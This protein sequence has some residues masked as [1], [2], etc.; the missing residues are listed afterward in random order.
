MPSVNIKIYKGHDKARR[1]SI[2]RRVTEAIS[3]ETK[4]PQQYIWVIIEES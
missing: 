4:V 1:D 2:A 3:E